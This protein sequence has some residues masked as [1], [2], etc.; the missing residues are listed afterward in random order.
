[1]EL[2]LGARPQGCYQA[3]N[4]LR[5]YAVLAWDPFRNFRLMAL[6]ISMGY[7]LRE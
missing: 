3:F 2:G 7:D 6:R 4:F 1:M 5:H